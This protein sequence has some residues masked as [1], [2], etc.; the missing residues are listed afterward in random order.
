MIAAFLPTLDNVRSEMGGEEVDIAQDLA[1]AQPIKK[2]ETKNARAKRRTFVH[3]QT[4][5]NGAN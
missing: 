4:S 5:E 3:Y 2:I 1:V